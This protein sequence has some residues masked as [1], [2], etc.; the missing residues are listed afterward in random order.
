MRFLWIIGLMAV[1]NVAVAT[2]AAATKPSY[3]PQ[4][5]AYVARSADQN[6]KLPLVTVGRLEGAKSPVHRWRMDRDYYASFRDN[7]L[8][9]NDV[10]DQ[11]A[12]AFAAGKWKLLPAI[13]GSEIAV[14]V[15]IPSLPN[16]SVTMGPLVRE[17]GV[18]SLA[19]N[20]WRSDP[21]IESTKTINARQVRVFY[22]P[23]LPEGKYQFQVQWCEMMP[24]AH[25]QGSDYSWTNYKVGQFPFEVEPANRRRFHE[26]PDAPSM[27]F[28]A[29]RPAPMPKAETKIQPPWLMTARHFRLAEDA[30]DELTVG[31]CQPFDSLRGN[32]LDFQEGALPQF[33]IAERNKS[34]YAMQVCAPM[35][36]GEWASVESVH[37]DAKVATINVDL[38]T[39]IAGRDKNVRTSP[40]LMVHLISP[41]SRAALEP[42]TPPGHYTVEVVTHRLQAD[43]PGG[44]YVQ[45]EEHR[46]QVQVDVK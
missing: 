36:F 30:K 10:E 35:N 3:A 1:A 29:L 23:P 12:A 17:G 21:A 41:E 34:L 2:E 26:P 5:V 42:I 28:D 31:A 44:W 37:W 43:Q 14:V 8:G 45:V 11:N 38:W 32:P 15:A 7:Q 39:D 27:T 16:A 18:L 40:V 25:E 46:R 13:G 6:E 20:V 22:L 19:I 9:I 4:P 33:Q 24:A